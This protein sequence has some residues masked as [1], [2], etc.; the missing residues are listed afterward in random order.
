MPDLSRVDFV[1]LWRLMLLA[2]SV[3]DQEILL[4]RQN[5]THFQISGAGH[6]C[7]QV[8][9]GVT[10]RPGH[11]WFYPYYRDRALVLTLGV[12]VADMLLAAAGSSEDPASSGRQMP[13]HWCSPRL[14]IVSQS[15]PTGTQFLQAVGTAEAD[16]RLDTPPGDRPVVYCSSGEGATSEGEFWESLNVACGLRL[17]VLYLIQDNAYA[18]SVPVAQQTA[19][20]S[21]SQLVRSF[22]ALHVEEVDGCDVQASLGSLS[23]AAEWCRSGGGPALVHA[24][25]IRPYSHSLSDD[26][27]QY[28]PEPE[29]IQEQQRDPVTV[30]ERWLLSSGRANA[31]Q[32]ASIRDEVTATIE[33]ATRTAMAAPMPCAETVTANVYSPEVDPTTSRF[34]T[35]AVGDGEDR[36]M[37]DLI[38]ACLRDEM[39]HDSKV[40]VF[41]EDVADCGIEGYLHRVK[42]KGGVFKVTHGLQR[43]FGSRRVFNSPL[44]EA[45]IVGRAI[46]LALRGL[47]PVVEI[48][49]MDY[50]W[51]AFMQIRDEMATMRW[52]SGGRFSCPLVVRVANG[53]YLH[54]GGPYHS[55][56]AESLLTHIPGLRVV[57]PSCAMDANGLLRTAIR[58]DDPVIFLEHK[59][60]Y[61]QTHNR[62]PYPGPDFMLPFG[63][64]RIVR[65]GTHVT[66]VTFGAM[67][68]RAIQAAREVAREG[69]EPEIVDLR[70]LQPFDW[71]TIADSI[72]RTNRV[73]VAHEDS[74]SWGYGAELSARI[75]AELFELLDAPV[76]RI[77]GR[78]AFVAYSPVL[79]AATLPQVADLVAAIRATARY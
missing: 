45:A 20:G 32:I 67:V 78:D 10:L 71:T 33:S 44:A 48:Q 70:T 11:D 23:R 74:L 59:H 64:A 4:K 77:G 5:R 1:R 27:T 61:R 63:R 7:V 13:S 75:A 73:I 35:P 3:D 14:H 69:I 26:E 39:A 47:K 51:P 79:E 65:P 12:T 38:N 55:Q 50:L 28:R 68:H 21:I 53:G 56:T 25:V 30:I 57:A 43:E 9:A 34:E 60:L 72:G 37:V 31:A 17:P 66:V 52:R 36:T 18:I 19:G 62:G 49:F 6:E 42:G 46:G 29:R 8:A 54:G 76:G 58:C 24:H 40:V 15:S 2:R 16:V 22:P 41:G